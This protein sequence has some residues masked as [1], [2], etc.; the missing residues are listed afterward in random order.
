MVPAS[1]SPE[2]MRATPT[3]DE[4]PGGSW[5]RQRRLG[6]GWSQFL[7]AEAY[8][9]LARGGTL[10]EED[11]V[12]FSRGLA[13]EPSASE[14]AARGCDEAGDEQA[15]GTGEQRIGAAR[16]IGPEQKPP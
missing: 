1:C 15:S 9:L 13:I 14:Q 2:G 8:G 7:R 4:R 5:P 6:P 3:P 11:R 10:D 16:P 12:S